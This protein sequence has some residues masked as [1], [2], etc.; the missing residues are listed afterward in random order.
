MD[1]YDIGSTSR[2]SQAS[3]ELCILKHSYSDIFKPSEVTS[4]WLALANI[5]AKV[6]ING[7]LVV[8]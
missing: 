4:M 7:L 2:C 5:E 1:I 6:S 3:Q 8:L